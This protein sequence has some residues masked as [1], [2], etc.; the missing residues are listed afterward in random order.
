MEEQSKNPNTQYPIPNPTSNNPNNPKTFQQRMETW[1]QGSREKPKCESVELQ[2]RE[3][4]FRH[5]NVR[6]W[7]PGNAEM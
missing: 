2:K 5:E 1:K 4:R 6:A 7:K 3:N